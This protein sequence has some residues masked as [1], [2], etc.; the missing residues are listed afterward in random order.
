MLVLFTSYAQLKKTSKT[1]SPALGD[2]GIII[3]EQGEGA[4]PHTLL[5]NF[6]NAEHAILLGTRSCWEGV[7]VP[8][9]ALSALVIVKLPFD[10]PSDPVIAARS[11][12][13]EDPFHQYALP[14]A[15]LRF[16]QGFGRLIRS[17]SDRGVV[18][19]LDRRVLTKRY[20]QLFVSSLPQC[21]QRVGPLQDLPREAA[22]W[23]NL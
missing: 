4:S 8:G 5:E 12:T 15:I 10:V 7:D 19:I 20:G 16:R 2:Q 13:F 21:T 14:E 18:A 1:I 22:T 11:E 3:Y 9:E 23:L 17:E 6:K